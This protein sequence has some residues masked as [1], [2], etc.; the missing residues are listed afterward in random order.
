MDMIVTI[1]L[2]P[3]PAADSH[4]HLHT[5]RY[6]I[7]PCTEQTSIHSLSSRYDSYKDSPDLKP[8]SQV[9][10]H[11]DAEEALG[12][13][14]CSWSTAPNCSAK[15]FGAEDDL[16]VSRNS[17]SWRAV[18]QKIPTSSIPFSP[19]VLEGRGRLCLFFFFSGLFDQDDYIETLLGFEKAALLLCNGKLMPR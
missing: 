14:S 16:R 19:F 1:A 2:R 12:C 10:V 17:A 11:D 8:E 13:Y 4:H 15:E 9:K 6:R 5:Y 18:K 7:K 3:K